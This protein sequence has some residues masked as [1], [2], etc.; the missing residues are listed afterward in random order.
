MEDGYGL[1]SWVHKQKKSKESLDSEQI[2]KLESLA[3]WEWKKIS[4]NSF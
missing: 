3:G 2:Q 4:R 1:G